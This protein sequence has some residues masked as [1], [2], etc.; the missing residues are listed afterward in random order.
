M[1]LDIAFKQIKKRLHTMTNVSMFSGKKSPIV[2]RFL[3][4]AIPNKTK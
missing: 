3:R 1:K 4:K 2:I